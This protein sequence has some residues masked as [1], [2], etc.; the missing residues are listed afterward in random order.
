MHNFIVYGDTFDLRLRNLTLILEG[1]V[2]TKLVLNWEKCHFMV[3][4][5]IFLACNLF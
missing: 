5:G 4:H 3:D 1:C 2:E